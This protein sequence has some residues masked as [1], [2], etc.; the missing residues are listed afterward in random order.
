M[1]SPR[2]DAAPCIFQWA[3][4]MK[5]HGKRETMIDMGP[6]RL[7]GSIGCRFYRNCAKY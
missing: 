4:L 7:Q 6:R 5:Q 1:R 3:A 2:H